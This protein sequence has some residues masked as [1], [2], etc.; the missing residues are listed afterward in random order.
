MNLIQPRVLKG[1]RDF[2]PTEARRRSMLKQSIRH[3]YTQHGFDEVE[4]PML[5][6]AEILMGKMGDEAEKLTYNFED[7]G[8]RHIALK[9]DHTVSFTRYYAQNFSKLAAPF[10]RFQ[11]GPVFRADKPQKSRYRQFD[12]F[13]ADII[14]SKSLNAETDLIA[15]MIRA[16]QACGLKNFKVRLNDRAL[17]DG[18]LE[19]IGVNHGHKVEVMH[20]ID[21]LHKIGMD[22]VFDEFKK[23][24]VSKAKAEQLRELLD[25][26]GNS[27]QQLKDIH[28][29]NTLR[30]EQIIST[31]DNLGLGDYIE[32]DF[33]IVRGLDYYT[34]VVLEVTVPEI[35]GSIGSGGRYDDLCSLFTRQKFSG[36]GL[37][38][39]IDRLYDALE[40]QTYFDNRSTNTKVLITVYGQG[41]Y[42]KSMQLQKILHQANVA[43]E[44]YPD[45]DD[46]KKQLKYANR[47]GI[48]FVVFA[49]PE[50]IANNA[51]TLK[52]MESGEQE[53][54][55]EKELV[56][57]LA[58]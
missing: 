22:A 46:L 58:T 44:V 30:L 56:A 49:G 41:T 18:I 1:F 23:I 3:V 15:M 20:V 57:R 7:H 32:F 16:Y 11:V 4:T 10:K 43:C 19:A 8:E 45:E 55:S 29:V 17:V 6:Y 14:G 48:P 54:L 31:L 47:K 52:D 13:D 9:Y 2:G 5:E 21:R 37:S 27:L 42:L 24:G 36:F 12:Q 39:G 35:A 33:T 28:G 40:A 53:S 51:F 26:H 34:G 38:I 25:V 50:E